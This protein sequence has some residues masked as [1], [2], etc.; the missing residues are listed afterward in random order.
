MQ[1]MAATLF[2]YLN[3]QGYKF[4]M[5]TTRVSS[6]VRCP[7]EEK[8]VSHRPQ[9]YKFSQ[10]LRWSRRR[11]A[12]TTLSCN[13]QMKLW[14]HQRWDKAIIGSFLHHNNCGSTR[15]SMAAS[16][17]N[18][19][20]SSFSGFKSQKFLHE[21]SHDGV[22]GTDNDEQSLNNSASVFHLWLLEAFSWFQNVYFL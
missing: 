14:K 9:K 21:C 5:K 19:L 20:P 11:R 1:A 7:L 16:K 6:H 13:I 22:S 17:E 4:S 8:G 2:R 3:E 15:P 12:T 10:R 18:K